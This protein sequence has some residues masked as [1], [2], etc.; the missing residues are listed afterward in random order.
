MLY[1]LLAAAYVAGLCWEGTSSA[2]LRWRSGRSPYR[3]SGLPRVT[4]DRMRAFRAAESEWIANEARRL[5]NWT[6]A[7]RAQ[8]LAQL[9]RDKSIQRLRGSFWKS[10]GGL[11]FERELGEMYRR[12]GYTVTQ[13]KASGDGGVDLILERDSK[14]IV[15]QCKQHSK[16]AGPSFV[17][18]LYGTMIHRGATSG[19]LAC[20][21]GFSREAR[22]FAHNKP[23]TLIGLSEILHLAAEAD[24]KKV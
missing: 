15:V 22:K 19:I 3:R 10:L 12:L 24:S 7:V 23:L 1:G 13:T 2:V 18:D 14:R 17:R 6:T 4:V 20:T 5:E 11:T 16:P 21:S 8:A 9:Q